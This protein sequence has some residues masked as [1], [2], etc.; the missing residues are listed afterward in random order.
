MRKFFVAVSV[1][2][3]AVAIA[4]SPYRDTRTSGTVIKISGTLPALLRSSGALFGNESVKLGDQTLVYMVKGDDGGLY[5]IEVIPDRGKQVSLVSIAT[6]V[7]I[8]TKI[9]FPIRER[10]DGKPSDDLNPGSG[11]AYTDTIGISEPCIH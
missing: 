8:G 10:K 2:V 1:L 6:R 11:S 4:C 3:L 5:T 7:C 9:S